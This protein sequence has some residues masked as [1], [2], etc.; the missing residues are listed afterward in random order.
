MSF[1]AY[2]GM[3]TKMKDD[4][5]RVAKRTCRTV[6]HRIR[7][8]VRRSRSCSRPIPN[9]LDGEC[10]CACNRTVGD[11]ARRSL[12]GECLVSEMR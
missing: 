7:S 6:S 2:I 4:H 9:V 1:M 8:A 10:Q 5:V 12:H 11:V 3:L